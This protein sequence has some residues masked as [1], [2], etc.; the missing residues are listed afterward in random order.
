MFFGIGHPRNISRKLTGPNETN[1]TAEVK[2]ILAAIEELKPEL[3]RGEEVVI[4][5]DSIYAMR[6]CGNYDKF[7]QR[8]AA[9]AWKT[10]SNTPIP[11]AALVEEAWGICKDLSSLEI[12]KVEGHQDDLDGPHAHGNDCADNLAVAG[13]GGRVRVMRPPREAASRRLVAACGR[14]RGA[15]GCSGDAGRYQIVREGAER[16]CSPLSQRAE[17]PKV[18]LQVPFAQKDEAKALGAWWNPEVKKWYVPS[19]VTG[20]SR[21]QMVKNWA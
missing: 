7:G 8:M 10:K 19:H 9:Q 20:E 17:G 14:G 15:G 6:V 1:N 4:H 16:H 13:A 21:A 2:A 12:V 3:E 5:T 11:N 18:W